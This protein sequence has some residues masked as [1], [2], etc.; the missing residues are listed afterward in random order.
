MSMLS[1]NMCKYLNPKVKLILLIP[2]AKLET[3]P[4]PATFCLRRLV[5]SQ[6]CPVAKL[7]YYVTR[8]NWF[9]R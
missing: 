3:E 7:L 1:I 5:D 4:T 2:K 9:I 6:G 8:S